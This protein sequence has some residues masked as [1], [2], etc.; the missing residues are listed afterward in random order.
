MMSSK[1]SSIKSRLSTSQ[2]L[3][4]HS[5]TTYSTYIQRTP[6][7][8]DDENDKEDEN[9][10]IQHTF[11]ADDDNN[12]NGDPCRELTSTYDY[13]ADESPFGGLSLF[14]F[15]IYSGFFAF[16]PFLPIMLFR[17]GFDWWQIGLVYSASFISSCMFS[18]IWHFATQRCNHKQSVMLFS[19]TSWIIAFALIFIV[20]LHN[21]SHAEDGCITVELKNISLPPLLLNNYSQVNIIAEK[22]VTKTTAPDVNVTGWT[23]TINY[24]FCVVV[25]FFGR[26]LQSPT[27]YFYFEHCYILYPESQKKRYKTSYH[28]SSKVIA[29]GLTI[30]VGFALDGI[31]FCD[32]T[33][34]HHQLS[35][36]VF[37]VMLAF[38]TFV[39]YFLDVELFEKPAIPSTLASYKR[40]NGKYGFVT[41]YIIW[42]CLLIAGIS[43]GIDYSIL[44][45]RLYS[46]DSSYLQ[47]A[48]LFSV[49]QVTETLVKLYRRK[50]ICKF[51]MCEVLIFFFYI[52]GIKNFLYG[53]I[54][55]RTKVW[56]LVPVEIIS[57][58]S[59]LM[60]VND[61]SE[62]THSAYLYDKISRKTFFVLFWCFGYS[63]GPALFGLLS[64]VFSNTSLFQYMA[65]VNASMGFFLSMC[66][67]VCYKEKP[68][69]YQRSHED[70]TENNN[71]DSGAKFLLRHH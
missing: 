44:P 42:G 61:N 47:I 39:L 63:V 65:V 69:M 40:S 16:L 36:Y 58:F 12:K 52:E 43:R 37:I 25:F 56:F 50:L 29:A 49:C 26:I 8:H 54:N 10:Q 17:H 6:P 55:S 20:N 11:S 64:R 28:I 22:N 35:F 38:A 70:E 21:A 41:K 68:G 34:G 24:A 46:I 3:P 67:L 2:T 1:T 4:K 30:A 48:I 57:G 7:G 33:F 66:Y 31:L 18:S 13:Q 51:G 15:L 9:Q 62:E 14:Y 19:L 23:V 5:T 27:D 45:L 32:P 59:A 71:E 60:F 53:I